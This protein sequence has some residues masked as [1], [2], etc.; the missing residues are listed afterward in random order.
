M[1]IGSPESTAENKKQLHI[2]HRRAAEAMMRIIALRDVSKYRS[3]NLD[4]DSYEGSVRQRLFALQHQALDADPKG[5]YAEPLHRTLAESLMNPYLSDMA[6]PGRPL[7]RDR[8]VHLNPELRDVADRMNTLGVGWPD[9]ETVFHDVLPEDF[10]DYAFGRRL[11]D[12]GRAYNNFPAILTAS[13]SLPETGESMI[14]YMNNTKLF[15]YAS[16]PYLIRAHALQPEFMGSLQAI[17]EIRGSTDQWAESLY[18]AVTDEDPDPEDQILLR[19]SR[20]SY[21]LLINLMRKDDLQIQARLLTMSMH[22]E[23]TDPIEELWT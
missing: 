6:Q 20:M 10:D 1:T 12:R 8:L 23:I 22:R 2:S 7:T 17:M 16:K 3:P 11:A 9:D 21:Q 14:D 5:E 13:P 18:R 19:A 15:Q 4:P